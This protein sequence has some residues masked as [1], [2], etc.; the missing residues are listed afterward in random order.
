MSKAVEESINEN[1]LKQFLEVH[2]RE[3]VNMCLTEFDEVKY[4]EIIREEGRLEGRMEGRLEG[5]LKMLYKLLDS[6]ILTRE[7]AIRESG[8]TEEEFDHKREE[9][10]Q[11]V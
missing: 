5:E 9:L 8:L 7:E 10:L 6:Q 2:R 1:V 3:V 4:S 11:L